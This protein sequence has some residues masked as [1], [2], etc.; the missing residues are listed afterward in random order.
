MPASTWTP[1]ALASEARPWAGSGWRAVEAQHKNATIA[2]VHGNV[3]DQALLESILEEAK[4]VLPDNAKGLHW[5][6]ATPFRYWPPQPAGSR[7]RRR[8]DPGVFYG[9]EDRQTSCAESGYWRLRL[10]MDSEGLSRH[11]AVVPV[12][13]FEF[14]AATDAAIDLTKAPLVKDRVLWTDPTD[15]RATQALAENARAVNVAVIRYASVRNPGGLCLALL[16]P[17]PFRAVSEPYDETRQQSWSLYLEPPDLTVWQRV[18][19]G[20]S[21]SFRF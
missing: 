6:L 10:W 21:F 18:L 15:Y 4:P 20:E 11:P 9:A 1:T 8:T 13:L 2:L 12:T 17:E 19:D 14:H 16:S 5:L 3:D 7:F